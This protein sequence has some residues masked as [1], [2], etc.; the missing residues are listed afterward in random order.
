MVVIVTMLV[1]VI[2]VIGGECGFCRWRRGAVNRLQVVACLICESCPMGSSE[3]C[4]ASYRCRINT[5]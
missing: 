5:M 3:R 4:W 1:E 2:V